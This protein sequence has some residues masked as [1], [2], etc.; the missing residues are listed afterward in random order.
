[1]IMSANNDQ[2]I[3]VVIQALKKYET[4]KKNVYLSVYR[5]SFI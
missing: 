3:D 2:E 1:M 4:R 5:F